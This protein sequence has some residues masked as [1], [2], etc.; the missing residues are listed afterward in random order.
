MLRVPA[1]RV[2][3]AV[4]ALLTAHVVIVCVGIQRTYITFDE[5]GHLQSGLCHWQTGTFGMY[6]VNPPLPRMLAT[7][8]V[9]AAQPKTDWSKLEHWQRLPAARAEFRMAEP[10]IR[11][12]GERLFPLVKIAR[13]TN[14]LWSIFGALCVF[15]WARRRFG[16][17]GG[18]LALG[19]WCFEPSL[20]GHAAVM[21]PDLPATAMGVATVYALTRYLELPT[22]WR[23][24]SVGLALGVA[25][26]TKL[27]MLLLIP[28]CIVLLVHAALKR[29]LRW[30][31][32][33][34]HSLVAALLALVI[35]NAGY[36]F[37]RSFPRLGDVPFVS[38]SFSGMPREVRATQ[39]VHAA[40]NRFANT[41]LGS[42]RVPV[43]ED[44]LRGMDVQRRDFELGLRS[45]LDGVWQNHG[46]LRYYVEG[47]ALKVPLGLWAMFLVAGYVALRTRRT[48]PPG[49]DLCVLV[50]PLAILAFVSS[51]TGF[52]H[53][54]RYVLPLFPFV[55]VHIG[56]LVPWARDALTKRGP[57]VALAAGAAFVSALGSVPHGIG[58]FN[59]LAGGV[60]GAPRHMLDSNLDW[61]Q[62]LLEL[63]AWL[64]EHPDPRPLHLAYFGQVIPEVEGIR[65]EGVPA[66][67]SF[68]SPD[69]EKWASGFGPK[70]GRYAVSVS[71]VYGATYPVGDGHWGRRK[72][73]PGDFAY[74]REVEPIAIVGSSIYV[75]DITP[76]QADRMRA[77]RG[78]PPVDSPASVTV[79]AR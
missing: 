25:L 12:N 54:V 20:V 44:L 40:G 32:L 43:P 29:G 64:A 42:V 6:R 3:L 4:V 51:Q 8:P 36:G 7:L 71:Y 33:L 45:Y 21:T 46:F 24:L 41:W 79:S 48:T 17:G 52:S 9:L 55:F 60:R 11:A 76:E 30:Q 78:M 61:G 73:I 16:D 63:Q 72:V 62:D 1:A 15:A 70:P 14:L 56:R 18:L 66:E 10:F 50:P 2:A 47:L 69:M 38:E 53:H 34:R 77:A 35:V 27:T 28:I 74:F 37:Q 58:Y 19:C 75:Y 22:L 31:S 59:A 5:P 26:L 23:G 57:V 13:Y 68:S 65:Y 49:A 39:G 67:P